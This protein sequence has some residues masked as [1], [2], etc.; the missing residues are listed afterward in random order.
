MADTHF[1][2]LAGRIESRTTDP[3]EPE[4]YQMYYNST[5][6]VLKIYIRTSWYGIAFS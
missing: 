6:N 1:S 2:K 5:T 4:Q 3:T